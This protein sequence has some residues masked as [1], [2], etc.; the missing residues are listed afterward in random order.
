M[1]YDSVPIVAN[2]KT[3]S[4][5]DFTAEIDTNHNGYFEYFVC[6]MDKCKKPDID[7]TCFKQGHCVKLMRVP[8]KDCEDPNVNTHYECGPIDPDY[9][10]RWYLPC[11]NT[12][13][14]GVHIV[15]GDSG[16]MRY[17]LPD[18]FKCDWCIVQWYWATANS[19]APRGFLAYFDTF[20]NPFGTK[21]ESDGGGQGAHR[22][23][24]AQCDASSVPEEFWSCADVQITD[25]GTSA[26]PV[27]AVGT[28]S[29]SPGALSEDGLEA[30]D[31]PDGVIDK[32]TEE[33]RKDVGMEASERSGEKKKEEERAAKG[34]CLLED[35]V[36]DS[37][38]YCCDSEMF[39]VYTEAAGN[40]TCRFWWSLW[41]DVDERKDKN[42]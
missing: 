19:C 5:V 9:P 7:G 31:D 20:N 41:K 12:G 6:N 8:H 32:V 39:C 28:P 33:V 13:H 27:K 16:T 3:G 23:N 36:C 34:E 29:P 40:F 15:G 30:Q 35:S 26:G 11:R 37:T 22:D 38:V 42:S 24:M 1:P 17:K 18:G 10:G 2:W 4:V 25:D 21:C 14:V